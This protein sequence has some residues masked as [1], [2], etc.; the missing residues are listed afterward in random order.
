MEKSISNYILQYPFTC[1]MPLDS[2]TTYGNLQ[3]YKLYVRP[4]AHRL[5]GSSYFRKKS[6]T[7]HHENVQRLLETFALYGTLTTWNMAKVR[8]GDDTSKVRTK[9]KEC[10]RL[11]IGRTDRGKRSNGLLDVGLVVKDGTVNNT[12][13]RYRLSLHGILYCLD[14]LD[15]T[16]GELDIIATKY[17][18]VLPKIFGKWGYLKSVVGDDVYKLRILAKGLTMDNPHIARAGV[19]MYELMSFIAIKYRKNFESISEQ[20]LANQISY[21]FYTN[22]LYS[23]D[24][25]STKKKK[26]IGIHRL[27]S[28][29]EG[30]KELKKWY[31]D[32]F[33]EAKSFYTQRIQTLKES[34]IF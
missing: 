17:V 15:L 2:N 20:E 5:F 34:T 19:P 10:R 27:K 1:G 21:W 31:I 22:L 28:L 26:N 25:R 4:M 8:F 32:F 16:N 11:L 30:D 29:L 23:R 18:K 14:V 7:K 33:Q 6:T 9:E 24:F 3:A 12:S 13:T